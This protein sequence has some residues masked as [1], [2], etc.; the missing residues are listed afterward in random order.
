VDLCGLGCFNRY[1]SLGLVSPPESSSLVE[2]IFR[3]DV[4]FSI[5]FSVL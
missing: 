4:S 1:D 5:S 3:V 2:V